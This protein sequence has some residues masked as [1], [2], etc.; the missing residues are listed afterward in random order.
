[1]PR[2]DADV[3]CPPIQVQDSKSSSQGI[4]AGEQAEVASPHGDRILKSKEK[5]VG[6][7]GQHS[8]P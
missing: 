2:L 4:E 6:N 3:R 8:R 1:M 7:R 5:S